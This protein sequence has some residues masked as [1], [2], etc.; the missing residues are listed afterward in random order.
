MNKSNVPQPIV[1][2]N[3]PSTHVRVNTV[4]HNS[5]SLSEVEA[6]KFKA[7]WFDTWWQSQVTNILKLNDRRVAWLTK[8]CEI[9][10]CITMLSHSSSSSC[11]Y[12]EAAQHVFFFPT[13]LTDVILQVALFSGL[14]AFHTI[15]PSLLWLV[16]G[17]ILQKLGA[18]YQ[19]FHSNVYC[20]KL[21]CF[22]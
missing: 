19:P 21:Y 14:F 8:R 17:M 15:L 16:A 1:I 4:T 12:L 10:M 20:L 9:G 11:L 6:V 7:F 13:L 5:D 18:L 2:S 22:S 3:H